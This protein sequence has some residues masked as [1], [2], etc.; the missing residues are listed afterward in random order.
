MTRQLQEPGHLVALS[1]TWYSSKHLITPQLLLLPLITLFLQG[2]TG[3]LLIVYL[4]ELYG[5]F[6]SMLLRC[7]TSCCCTVLKSA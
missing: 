5:T 3:F 1:A 4:S 2:S 7:P 6:R